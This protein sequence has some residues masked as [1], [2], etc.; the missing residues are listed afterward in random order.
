MWGLLAK[1]DLPEFFMEYLRSALESL[2]FEANEQA[3]VY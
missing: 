1:R 2:H 3:R